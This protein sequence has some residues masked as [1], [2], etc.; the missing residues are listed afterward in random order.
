LSEPIRVLLVDDE[1]RFVET[2]ARVL[3]RKGMSVR[4]CFDGE[5]AIECVRQ[6]E[7]DV[8]VLDLRMPKM[9]GVTALREIKIINPFTQVILLTGGDLDMDRVAQALKNGT[10]DV[11]LKPCSTEALISTIENAS[12]RKTITAEMYARTKR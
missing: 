8:V 4:T 6:E 10:F 9:D 1:K 12:E 5:T 2:T 3:R 11:L 7:C